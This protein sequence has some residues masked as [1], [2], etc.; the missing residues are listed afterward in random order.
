MLTLNHHFED[1]TGKRFG[2]F[3]VLS[4]AGKPKRAW[5]WNCRCDCGSL[6]KV[7]RGNLVRSNPSC[8]CYR[9]D[10]LITIKTIH[11]MRRTRPYRIWANMKSRCINP[12]SNRSHI[13]FERGIRVCPEWQTFA[14]FWRDMEKGYESHL[15]I[16]RKDNSLGYNKTNCIWATYSQQAR[17]RRKPEARGER[18]AATAV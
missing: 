16:E 10:N 2:R 4:L 6:R 7:P 15:T 18:R 9:H 3:T 8:G 17:N 13:Y 1:L 5:L 12:N 14:G 11:G